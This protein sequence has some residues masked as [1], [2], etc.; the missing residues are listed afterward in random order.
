[1]AGDA[2]K[3]DKKKEESRKMDKQTKENI[4]NFIF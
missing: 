1:M 2:D 3:V 4:S